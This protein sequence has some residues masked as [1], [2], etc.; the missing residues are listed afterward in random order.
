[1]D[2]VKMGFATL[3]RWFAMDETHTFLFGL[4]TQIYDGN[5]YARIQRNY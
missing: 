3:T 1:M 5:A 2:L 4:M